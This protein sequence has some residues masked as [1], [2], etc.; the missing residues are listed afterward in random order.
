MARRGEAPS[1]FAS[2]LGPES[3]N[4]PFDPVEVGRRMAALREELGRITQ[5]QLAERVGGTKRGIQENESGK[6]SPGAKVLHALHL[7]G[8]NLGWLLTG[9][10]PIFHR[11]L[12]AP[13]PPVNQDLLSEVIAG[14]EQHLEAE[15]LMLS[16]GKKAQLVSLLYEQCSAE[17]E[18]KRATIL[19]LVKLAA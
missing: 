3:A 6:S 9:H 18:V 4:A 15:G 2:R 14:V 7:A 12:V 19:R 11:E 13:R 16:P 17:G 8:V 10:G 5:Q 1:H